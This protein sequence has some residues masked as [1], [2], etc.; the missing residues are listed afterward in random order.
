MSAGEMERQVSPETVGAA[1]IGR[2]SQFRRLAA[3]LVL[4]AAVLVAVALVRGRRA[5]KRG[6]P[7]AQVA[8]AVDTKPGVAPPGTDVGLAVCIGN[9]RRI[10]AALKAYEA[11]HGRLPVHYAGPA[12]RHWIINIEPYLPPGSASLFICPD[13]ATRGEARN[14]GQGRKSSYFYQYTRP[15][16]APGEKYRQPSLR[17]PLLNCTAHPGFGPIIARYDGTLDLSPPG[18]YPQISV[19][20]DP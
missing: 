19:E 5:E 6:E 16:L 3:A 10:Y 18:R 13:D 20:F 2:Q 11:D 4:L 17:S 7:A 8:A 15:H 1:G 9:M 14:W 12:E